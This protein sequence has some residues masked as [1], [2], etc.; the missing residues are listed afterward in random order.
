MYCKILTFYELTAKWS[1]YITLTNK[2][3]WT[4]PPP[5]ST[6]MDQ[7]YQC[8][9]NANSTAA[10]KCIPRNNCIPCCDAE[11]ENLYQTFLQYPEGH[12]SSRAATAFQ[13][14][15]PQAAS[16]ERLKSRHPFASTARKLSH[17]LSELGIRAV[18]WTNLTWDTEYSKSISALGVYI[19]R[20]SAR[21]IGMSSTRTA[22][23][24]QS[25]AT[26]ARR[27]DSSMHKWG[28]ASSAKCECG[29]SEQTA[30]H[31]ILTSPMHR[32]PRGIMGLT[33]LNDETRYWPSSVTASIRSRQHSRL[34]W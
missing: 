7:A 23:V 14:T 33:V 8:F 31:I 3:A 16:K 9:C 5:D 4:L 21:P 18:Q 28:L 32:A 11:C 29:A 34:G 17:N 15:E 20:V 6:D 2:L 19:P 1:H 22:W 13:L 12:G 26:N 25:S 10:K 27:F 24:T 30:D